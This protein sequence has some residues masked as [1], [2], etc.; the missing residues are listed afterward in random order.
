MSAVTVEYNLP[1]SSDLQM[2]RVSG[3]ASPAGDLR[4]AALAPLEAGSVA[5][6]KVFS[7]ELIGV[8]PLRAF[9]TTFVVVALL[10][11]I[12]G[13]TRRLVGAAIADEDQPTGVA[14][15]TLQA[16]NRIV[17]PLIVRRSRDS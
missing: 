1:D 5:T 14:L 9:D 2:A 17:A 3:T 7:A 11:R 16:V 6:N 12:D 8:K 10:A 4:L 13:T 15:A